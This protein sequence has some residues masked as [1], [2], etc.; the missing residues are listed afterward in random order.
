MA[1]QRRTHPSE[2]SQFTTVVWRD[3]PLTLK[4]KFPMFGFMRTITKDP[5]EG[6][7]M[8][9][10]EESLAVL[11]EVEMDFA[12]LNNLI[13]TISEGLGAKNAGN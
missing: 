9:L 6:I 13:E 7:A 4:K 2:D 5:I 12:D 1:T 10:S 11:E 3:I 8:I